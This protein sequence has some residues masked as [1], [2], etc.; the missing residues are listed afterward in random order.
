[1]FFDRIAGGIKL[2]AVS[3]HVGGFVSDIGLLLAIVPPVPGVPV[4]R[5]R[6]GRLREK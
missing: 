1:M 6:L 5:G 3:V 2:A 4:A